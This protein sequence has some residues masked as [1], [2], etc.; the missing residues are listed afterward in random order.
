M[1]GAVF[2]GAMVL[3]FL[4][5]LA[6][7]MAEPLHV[8]AEPTMP[9]AAAA[10]PEDGQWTRPAQNDANTLPLRCPKGVEPVLP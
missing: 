9:P 8:V 2:A 4:V 3:A 5:G 1:R 10:P 6:Q 7:L